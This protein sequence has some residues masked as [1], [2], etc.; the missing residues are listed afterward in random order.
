MGAVPAETSGLKATIIVDVPKATTS[1]HTRTAAAELAEQGVDLLL[2]AGGDG[3]A[4]DVLTAVGDRVVTLGIPCG[5]K[6]HSAC[7]AGGA[8]SAG[9]LSLEF[10]Q[11]QG[12]LQQAEVLD[13]DEEALR[14][15]HLAP[16]LHGHLIVPRDTRV[17]PGPKSRTGPGDEAGLW[18]LA[19]EVIMRL[20]RGETLIVGPGTTTGAVM[21][22]LGL[23]HTLLGVDVIQGDRVLVSDAAESDLLRVLDQARARVLVAPIGGQGFLLGRGNQQI[24]PSVLRRVGQE[25]LL[26]VATEHK[27]ATLAGRP[28]R[29]DTGDTEVDRALSGY[30]RIVTGPGRET[31]YRIA[32]E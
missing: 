22:R 27:L 24:S 26:V 19:D 29:V 10:L 3:T 16:R 2:F 20:A 7:F 23:E 8:R 12:N 17:L 25:G 11:R 15:G 21:D 18:A 6:M 31:V 5:V 4:V 28:L 13:V 30:V 9:R 32:A 14:A 1:A